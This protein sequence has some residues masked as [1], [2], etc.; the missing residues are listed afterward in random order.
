MK[1]SFTVQEDEALL[2]F[3]IENSSKYDEM[4]VF[5]KAQQIVPALSENTA[6]ELLLR[7]R[8]YLYPM[9]T[10]KPFK[11]T[12]EL[13]S[14]LRNNTSSSPTKPSDEGFLT[15]EE[16]KA[17]LQFIVENA[18]HYDQY[19]IFEKAR[20]QFSALSAKT[21][22]ELYLRNHE[23][24]FPLMTG[25]PSEHVSSLHPVL[26]EKEFINKE[27]KEEESFTVE[28]DTTL[29]TFV[30]DNASK[31]DETECFLKATQLEPT[32]SGFSALELYLRYY[33]HLFPLITGQDY[34]RLDLFPR[35]NKFTLIH[36]LRAF[37]KPRMPIPFVNGTTFAT[38]KRNS[39]T[40]E[41]CPMQREMPSQKAEL[42]GNDDHPK[43]VVNVVPLH[44]HQFELNI[45]AM[46]ELIL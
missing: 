24:L 33:E 18:H 9:I 40:C 21:V 19:E 39:V 10:G 16:D 11:E 4:E 23:Y 35:W 34:K 37:Q 29:L 6:L 8:E 3:L 45:M 5:M 20:Q 44:K 43:L 36:E 42:D 1:V 7:Y 12:F 38:V 2:Q 32:L 41:L 17:L 30:I 31:Y 46:P 25:Q 14:E 28:Q 15:F 27:K 13:D 22:L 26:L